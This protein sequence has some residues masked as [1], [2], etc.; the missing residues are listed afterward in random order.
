MLEREPGFRPV[1]LGKIGA[2]HRID[3]A[4]I[5]HVRS[6]QALGSYATSVPHAIAQWAQ[7]TP[8]TIMVADRAPDGSWRT[9]TYGQVMS[10]IAPLAQALLDANLSPDRPLVI[11]SGNEIE[12]LLLGL[13]AIWVGI[14]YTPVSPAYSLISTDYA[15]LKHIMALLQPGMVYASDGNAFGPAIAAAVPADVPV[16]VRHNPPQDRDC[17]T[18]AELE[19][20]TPGP[21][22]ERAHHGV[23]GDTIA[24]FLFTSGSTGM[25]KAVITTNTMM[26][27]NQ[28]MIRTA[29]P[30]LTDE[31]PIMVDWMPWNHVA[32]GSHNSG[33]AFYN[34]GTLYIDD[35]AATPKGIEKTVRN[36]IDVEPTVYFNVPKGFEM[37]V[38]RFETDHAFRGAFFRRMKLLQY[39]GAGLSQYVW[40][41]LDAA[42]RAETGQRITI[43]T[44]Y[45]STETAPFA[46]TT[47]WP[48]DRAG[49]V[50][51]PAAGMDIKLVPNGDKMELRLKGPNVTPGYW[52]DAEKTREA[53]DED[54]YYK[55]GDALKF[56]DP[57]ELSK[58]FVFDGRVSE[59]FKLSTGTWV[60]FASVRASMIAACAPL[61]RD[62]V[63][64]GLDR[65]FIGALIFPDIAACR[66]LSGLGDDASDADVLVAPDVVAAF[67]ERLGALAKKATGSSNHVARAIIM[68]E[69]PRIDLSEVTDKGSINQRAV[70]AARGDLVEAIYS[71]TPSQFVLQ[72]NRD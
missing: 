37:L 15:K 5:V 63:L 1:R 19:A 24:K 71:V 62:V 46:F 69:P 21:G 55:I 50:G 17:R 42:A 30:F 8:D 38:A 14:P 47:T 64:T 67:R 31:P 26:A 61:M 43:I 20:T 11:L 23:T 25:P 29:L 41:G 16:V 40:D 72:F 7:S 59:D 57:N 39:A 27:C 36:I 66:T 60:N 56:A 33:I 70:I 48:V 45:G 49:L 9:L 10:R 34:G 65:N 3:A 51:L 53:F 2:E 35:G 4:G 28:E 44:G 52:K 54:G 32:G 12:H 68:T 18:I 58:G 22:V 6:T 13:A